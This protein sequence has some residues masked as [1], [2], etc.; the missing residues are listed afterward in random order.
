MW[1][2]ITLVAAL[3]Q[4]L[5]TS[6]Q[7]RLRPHLSVGQAGY[8]RFVFAWPIA[9]MLL[10]GRAATAW[11]AADS[12]PQIDAEFALTVT[13]AGISQIV[14]TVA[15]LLAFRRRDFAVGTVYVKSEVAIV[16]LASGLLLTE[17]PTALGWIGVGV[18]TAGIIVL[19][20]SSQA[21]IGQAATP[22][23]ADE[24]TSTSRTI[25]RAIGYGLGAAIGFALAAVGIRASA[26]AISGVGAFDRAL[27]TLWSMLGVQVV[28]NGLWLRFTGERIGELLRQWRQ[29]LGVGVL[30]MA[31]S[32]G[33]AWAIA[34]EGPTKVRTLGQVE[35]IFAFIIGVMVHRERYVRRE[36]V[37]TAV[38]GG[39]II[40]IVLS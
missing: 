8:A 20:L 16:A 18:V 39:G 34:L 7:H 4:I 13:G 1:I 6:E 38:V 37:A 33:W 31:G 35:L 5:R 23:G 22:T 32:V 17:W 12:R 15:L 2:P 11:G 9:T 40:A 21:P 19:A 3:C 30:S 10:I 29:C 28:I 14:G 27:I 26:N 25:D 36:Y 24:G